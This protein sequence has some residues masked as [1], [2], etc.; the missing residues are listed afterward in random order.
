MVPGAYTHLK[1]YHRLYPTRLLH[2]N[3]NYV[4]IKLTEEKMKNSTVQEETTA[5]HGPNEG[6]TAMVFKGPQQFNNKKTVQ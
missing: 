6:L 4:S 1:M 5:N 2:Y 3:I